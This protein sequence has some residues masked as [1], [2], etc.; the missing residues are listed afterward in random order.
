MLEAMGHGVCAIETNE[1]DSVAAADRFEPD[2]MLVDA[3]LRHGTG[4]GAV[5][6]ILRARF[7][8]HVFATGDALSVLQQ[9]PNSVVLQKPFRVTELASAI[10]RAMDALPGGQSDTPRAMV[11]GQFGE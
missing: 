6:R 2:L 8:P 1:A 11:H 10:Q 4:V 9:R 7:V 3:Q 5:E